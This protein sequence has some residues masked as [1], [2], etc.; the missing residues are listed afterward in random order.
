M[1]WW[2][3]LVLLFIIIVVVVVVWK[4]LH[5]PYY[6]KDGL[7]YAEVLEDCEGKKVEVTGEIKKVPYGKSN[8]I[9]AYVL[10]NINIPPCNPEP[11]IYFH[12]DVPWIY[13]REC[14]QTG[15]LYLGRLYRSEGVII[16]VDE[17]FGE[18]LLYPADKTVKVTG[19]VFIHRKPSLSSVYG[20]VGII[21]ES[22]TVIENKN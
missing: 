19:K 22:I 6:I 7:C 8:D 21:P 13:R 11:K 10:N 18:L 16:E 14:F 9:K 17:R 3:K 1:S 20:V 12:K 2:K 5:K 15:Y 4:V